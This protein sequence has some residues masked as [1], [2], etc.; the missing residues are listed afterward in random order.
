MG[1]EVALCHQD[2][3]GGWP[4]ALAETLA[5]TTSGFEVADF[6]NFLFHSRHL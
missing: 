4:F 3:V 5:Q 6:M 1:R 2:P